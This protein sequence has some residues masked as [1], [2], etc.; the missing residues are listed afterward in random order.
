[1]STFDPDKFEFVESWVL[2][3]EFWEGVGD[4]RGV[5]Q[6]GARCSGVLCTAGRK[7]WGGSFS[8]F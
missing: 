5:T 8:R 1:M 4:L 6:G 3:L 2:V 7:S